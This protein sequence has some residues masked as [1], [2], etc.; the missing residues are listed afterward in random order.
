MDEIHIGP[1]E[2]ATPPR[3][4]PAWRRDATGRE[5]VNIRLREEAFRVIEAEA[6]ADLHEVCGLLIGDA[7]TWDGSLYIDVTAALP[8]E[9][10]NAGPVHV[11]FTADTWVGLLRE[12]ERQF[13]DRWIVGWYHS[14]P[15][16]AIFLSDADTPLHQHFFPEPWHVA[17]VINGQDRKLGFFARS[18]DEI[19]PV[20]DFVWAPARK[21]SGVALNFDDVPCSYEL[22][23]E[24]ERRARAR[25]RASGWTWVL[26]AFVAI[27][28]LTL[29]PWREK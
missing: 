10:T 2:S 24:D 8:G 20:R 4:R 14:H 3:R 12:K 29:R 11:T 28:V 1:T 21:G 15:R 5:P 18:G 17:L 26:A 7:V 16:M 27:V 9:R 13:P 23:P 6:A 19:Q 22:V 25:A